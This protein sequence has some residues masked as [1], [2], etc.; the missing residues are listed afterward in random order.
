MLA[1]QEGVLKLCVRLFGSLKILAVTRLV[2]QP[3]M[4]QA[5]S[6]ASSGGKLD[7][8]ARVAAMNGFRRGSF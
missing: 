3:A 5:A 1:Q 2:L 7:R 6:V 4:A 8:G